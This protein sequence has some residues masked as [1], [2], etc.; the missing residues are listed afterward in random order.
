MDCGINGAAAPY[1][2]ACLRALIA[3]DAYARTFQ[4]MAQ[5]RT[6]LLKH[7]DNLVAAELAAARQLS[8]GVPK[9]G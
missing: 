4:T 1:C 6:A 7:I 9:H 5:Y 2:R 3:D 8:E